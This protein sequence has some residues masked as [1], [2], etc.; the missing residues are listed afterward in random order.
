MLC[1][2]HIMALSTTSLDDLPMGGGGGP[3]LQTVNTKIPNGAAD[4]QQQRDEDI[5][6][7]AG[8]PPRGEIR[9]SP[10]A[11]NELVTGLQ[12]AA[13]SGMTQLPARDVPRATQPVVVDEQVKPNYVPTH[14]DYI[15]AHNVQQERAAVMIKQQKNREDTKEVVYDELHTPILLAALFFMFQ[16]PFVRSFMMKIVPMV[17]SA[18]GNYNLYGYVLT[19]LLFAGTF[20]SL[21]KFTTVVSRT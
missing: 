3:P 20:Y 14:P 19:S 1:I 4:L 8:G 16:L 13:A 9:P 12:S 2:E 11:V 7:M 17:F 21:T 5:A 6:R 10:G 15:S 18:D